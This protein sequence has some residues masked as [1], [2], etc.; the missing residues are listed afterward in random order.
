MDLCLGSLFLEV[1]VGKGNG[2]IALGGG[3]D[4]K[5]FKAGSFE[6]VVQCTSIKIG[7]S[8]SKNVGFHASHCH[9]ALEEKRNCK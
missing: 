8:V 6:L 5:D 1:F 9:G 7:V 2:G 3:G 4:T